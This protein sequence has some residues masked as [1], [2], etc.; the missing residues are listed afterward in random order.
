MG[1][2][3]KYIKT[4]AYILQGFGARGFLNWIPDEMYLKLIYRMRVGKKLDLKNPK[5]FNEKLQW[6]KLHDRNPEYIKLVDKLAVRKN[7]EEMIGEEYLI[8]LIGVWDHVDDIDFDSLPDQFVLKCTHDSGSAIICSDKKLLDI[9]KAKRSLAKSLRKKSFGYGRE[10]T[11]INVEPRIIAEKFMGDE[12]GLGLK[13]YKIL[14]F[15]GEA[16]CSFVCLNRYSKN[17]LNVDF[18]DMDWVPMPFERHY[19]KSGTVIP[20]PK[21]FDRMVQIAE[22]LSSDMIFVRMDFYEIDERVYFGE[23]TFFPGSGFEEFIP[24]SYDNL[25]GSWIKLNER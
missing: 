7:I 13:D 10:W 5:G 8:P 4:P 25:L 16:K 19:K 17:G 9:E 14:C 24:D 21:T 2:L 3:I 18:Y 23:F 6:L 20:K 11:Y 12:G 15:N 22:E 1:K